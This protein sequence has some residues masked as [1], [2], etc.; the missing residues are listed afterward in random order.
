M[1]QPL[2][3]FPCLWAG[4]HAQF[5]NNSLSATLLAPPWCD[6]ARN[7]VAWPAG[8][9]YLIRA[10]DAGQATIE[11]R[12]FRRETLLPPIPDPAGRRGPGERA[13]GADVGTS[14]PLRRASPPLRYRLAWIAGPDRLSIG[15]GQAIS[16]VLLLIPCVWLIG[17][18]F[19]PINHDV[20]A[21]LD[22][23]RRWLQGDR[24]YVDIIDINTP[25]VFVLHA[26]PELLARLAFDG[27]V[28]MTICVI[29]GVLVSALYSVRALAF[30]PS[31]QQPLMRGF[32]P[33]MILF[34]LAVFPNDMFGQREHL[35][36]IFSFPY[37]ILAA[38]RAEKAHI[39]I[40][41]RIGVALAG[42]IGFSLKPH[43]LLLPL[44]LELHVM[45][46]VGWRAALRDL[47]PWVAAGV[48]VA[49][50]AF[51]LL[52]TPEYVTFLIPLV[53]RFYTRIGGSD[54]TEVLF[55]PLIGP[56]L[57]A[58][59]PL[60]GCA[61]FL[62]RSRLTRTLLVYAV[63][64][65]II[66]TVQAK[67]WRYQ[68]LPA[69]LAT[70][71]LAAVTIAEMIDRY[72]P[73]EQT[74]QRLPVAVLSATFMI[75]FYYQQALFNTPFYKQTGFQD[76]VTNT[77]IHIID[78]QAPSRRV[79]VLSPGI[80]PHYPAINYTGAHMTMPFQTMWLL[81]GVYADCG[82][83]APLYNAPDQMSKAEKFIFNTVSR[84]FAQQ[85]PDL[86]IVD[87]I[88]GIPRCQWRAFDYLE[89]FMRNPVFAQAFRHYRLYTEFDRYA[90]YSRR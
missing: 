9:V 24:L 67:G 27:P 30:V 61:L 60:A 41:L 32:L 15:A 35:L 44:L 48:T 49:H 2:A 74:Q 23:A 26:I 80:Y 40:A 22:V 83:Y 37:V 89:Y 52:V 78:T 56:T 68:S 59:V 73:R 42:G 72:L 17:Y 28:W 90:I 87:K 25:L 36:A 66:C 34:L 6:A 33:P 21:E 43:F 7:S 13:T 64:A 3:A 1:F 38:A 62:S 14:A 46:C 12:P 8:R 71:L 63:G 77:L 5:N 45:V 10:G 50:I 76:S 88:A 54:A 75:L 39:P 58:L 51:T 65:M 81:Q 55:G 85:R 11:G 19:P 16:W 86:I 82:E 29:F 4:R 18:L 53:M 79:L 47:V 31:A 57:L 70:L 69:L 20:G 84:D